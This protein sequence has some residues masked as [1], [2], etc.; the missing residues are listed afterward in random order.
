[1]GAFARNT[2]THTIPKSH[3]ELEP[4]DQ[5]LMSTPAIVS[6]SMNTNCTLPSPSHYNTY[7]NTLQLLTIKQQR[8][9]NRVRASQFISF[10]FDCPAK[11]IRLPKCVCGTYT[12]QE[13]KL[14][15]TCGV[16]AIHKHRP[17][18]TLIINCTACNVLFYG[19]HF[20]FLPENKSPKIDGPHRGISE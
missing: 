9:T 14:N 11:F 2:H 7:S 19:V 18:K 5:I 8:Q 15:D 17:A 16:N 20:E 1:M 3:D 4:F 10:R 12:G 13:Y 6:C